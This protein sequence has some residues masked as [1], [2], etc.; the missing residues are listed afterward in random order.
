[1][2]RLVLRTSIVPPVTTDLYP[3][4]TALDLLTI[5]H[6]AGSGAWGAQLE[7]QAP[8]A[9]VTTR[10][11]NAANASQLET[12]MATPGSRITLTGNIAA[13][14]VSFDVT[15]VDIIVP[16]GIVVDSST[17]SSG[18]TK[19]RLRIRKADGD[20]IG[21]QLCGMDFTGGT[22]RDL[23]IDGLQHSGN[24]GG[25]GSC[26]F[27]GADTERVAIV[28]NRAK[29]N[30]CVFGYGGRHMVFAGNSIQ[31]DADNTATTGDWGFRHADSADT[32]GPYVYFQNDIRG[33]TFAPLRFHTCPVN[34]TPYYVW[35]A[36]NNFSS[37]EGIFVE[38]QSIV[39]HE[40][41]PPLDGAWILNNTAY[42][43][44]AFRMNM[45]EAGVYTRINGNTIYGHTS[46]LT[47]GDAVDA[48][49]SGNTYNAVNP[50]APAWGAAG[51]PTGIDLTP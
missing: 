20:T 37:L 23:I 7:I 14:G 25:D 36:E 10:N 31:H 22:V 51:D 29:S 40:A 39:G 42:M 28:N 21:G 46:G 44:G 13:F 19:T 1:M 12:E 45:T 30:K 3:W 18:G 41:Y 24:P 4:Y 9:P 17:W 26:F 11:V 49:T 35:I 15:D 38:M 48:D 47:A 50:G 32:Y 6:H 43:P 27:F 2:G 5:P 33:G 8:A 34:T 16:N